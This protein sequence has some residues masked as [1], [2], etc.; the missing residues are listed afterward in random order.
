[1]NASLKGIVASLGDRFSEYLSRSESNT[2]DTVLNGGEF[3]GVGI[4]VNPERRGLRVLNVIPGSPAAKAKIRASD[5]VVAVNGQSIAGA[6]ART[7]STKI[8]GKPG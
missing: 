6:A 8:R 7:A 1:E 2:F 3:A 4:T 5:I